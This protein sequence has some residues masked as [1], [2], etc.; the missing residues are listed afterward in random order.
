MMCKYNYV[1]FGGLSETL[2][3]PGMSNMMIMIDRDHGMIVVD[4]LGQ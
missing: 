3:I 2:N 1:L 4:L